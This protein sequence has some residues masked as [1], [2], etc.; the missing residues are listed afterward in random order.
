MSTVPSG[1]VVIDEKFPEYSGPKPPRDA[2]AQTGPT[3]TS[4]MRNDFI[5]MVKSGLSGLTDAELLAVFSLVMRITPARTT[6]VQP[7]QPI[8]QAVVNPT[9]T[10]AEQ[11]SDLM[12]TAFHV[13]SQM[14][15]DLRAGLSKLA[16]AKL[17]GNVP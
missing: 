3:F 16:S 15:D 5:R 7:Q 1:T 17:L 10:P 11:A 9:R 12:A 14:P 13:W 4:R 2:A 8:Q 6:P